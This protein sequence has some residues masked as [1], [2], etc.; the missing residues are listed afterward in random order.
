MSTT[1][2]R[3][4][5]ASG[6]KRLS[7]R[8]SKSSLERLPNLGKLSVGDSAREIDNA[9]HSASHSQ[10]DQHV[11]A[12]TKL[13]GAVKQWLH[14]ERTKWQDRTAVHGIIP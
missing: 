14:E 6:A 11:H 2:S 10:S 3:S 4:R 13:H 1:S 12:H 5:P 9:S 7:G 8:S